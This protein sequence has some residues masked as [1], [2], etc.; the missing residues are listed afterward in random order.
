MTNQDKT[1]QFFLSSEIL[2]KRIKLVV[3][4]YYLSG[5]QYFR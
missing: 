2:N 5:I 4:T 1:T 3:K